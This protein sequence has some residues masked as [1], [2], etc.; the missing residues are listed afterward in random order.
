M[1]EVFLYRC[2]RCGNVIC[3]LTDRGERFYLDKCLGCRDWSDYTR[4]YVS[5]GINMYKESHFLVT[6]EKK[7][8]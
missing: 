1:K 3:E 8:G 6:E 2:D 7:D 4:V 5:Q